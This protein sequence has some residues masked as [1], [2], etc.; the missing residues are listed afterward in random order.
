[1]RFPKLYNFFRRSRSDTALAAARRTSR[2]ASD[3]SRRIR[4]VSSSFFDTRLPADDSQKLSP[5]LSS[6]PV[7]PI[8]VT[9]TTTQILEGNDLK[10]SLVTSSLP[11]LPVNPDQHTHG[12]T[13][14]KRVLELEAAL[15]VQAEAN[16]RMVS[17]LEEALEAERTAFNES[18][19]TNTLLSAD[20]SKLQADVM[21]ARGELYT[22]LHAQLRFSTGTE[23]ERNIA[24]AQENDRLL[25]FVKL[26]ISCGAHDTVLERTCARVEQGYDPEESVVDAIK[27]AMEDPE[28]IWRRLLDPLVGSRSP[29][30]YLAQTK[31]TLKAR[32]ESRDWQ[33]RTRFWKETARQDGRH[34]SIVTPSVSQLSDVSAIAVPTERK[35]VL[36]D[37]LGKL[38]EGALPLTMETRA[39]ALLDGSS[40]AKVLTQT[41]GLPPPSGSVHSSS[42]IQAGLATIVESASESDEDP[43]ATSGV[44][45][46]QSSRTLSPDA[47]FPDGHGPSMTLAPLA[48]IT[49]RE[50]HSIKSISSR[51]RR[52]RLSSSNSTSS[53][54][55][56][57][58][59]LSD[60]KAKVFAASRSVSLLD[61]SA[62]LAVPSAAGLL[63]SGASGS[64]MSFDST[65]EL[66]RM[67]AA[68][69]QVQN[70][71][72][73]GD[74]PHSLIPPPSEATT[75]M[76]STLAPTPTR[77]ALPVASTPP[78]KKSPINLNSPPPSQSYKRATPPPPATTSSTPA[79]SPDA[80]KSKLPVL[81]FSSVPRTIRR[82]L[83]I[84]RPVLV[85][86]TNAGAVPSS[87][88]G[89]GFVGVQRSLAGGG[90]EKENSS[91]RKEESGVGSSWAVG[92]S[93]LQSKMMSPKTKSKMKLQAAAGGRGMQA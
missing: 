2:S 22:A 17:V 86:T 34:A 13:L 41:Q 45:A 56:R 85:D 93:R 82:R 15:M 49:F 74:R 87:K 79:S 4:P 12:P 27:L 3:E 40:L 26:I 84:S 8:S 37:M 32:R 91:L 72:L 39:S 92:K 47:P 50:S 7:D 18:Q 67:V 77:L 78:R 68:T 46:S 88:T 24:L 71:L 10:E 5:I 66:A 14:A 73:H 43:F 1:M 35:V 42:T 44:A 51:R 11:I 80:K 89:A 19:D 58:S 6:V 62:S 59:R 48:S 76:T 55:S 57:V 69:V 64:G 54:D 29:Q 31:C 16:D 90:R 60:R 70:I 65:E 52:S 36:D 9:K 61:V 20:I 83:S 75:M 21:H 81:K 63:N 25:R 38:R 30:D 23:S 53:Q 33:K 28:S